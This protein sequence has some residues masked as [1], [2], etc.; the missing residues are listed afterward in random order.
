M[1][2]R[3]LHNLLWCR[4]LGICCDHSL[5][6]P[7]DNCTAV[8]ERHKDVQE[9]TGSV[10][11]SP[12]F[13]SIPAEGYLALDMKFSVQQTRIFGGVW[14]QTWSSPILKP[15]PHSLLPTWSWRKNVGNVHLEA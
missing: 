5:S 14:F 2:R 6:S 4:P 9:D 1:S 3:F 10:T 8:G 11:P 12:N 13:H 15:R 7:Y